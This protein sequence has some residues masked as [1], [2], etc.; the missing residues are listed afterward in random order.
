VDYGVKRKKSFISVP[1]KSQLC[2]CTRDIRPSSEKTHTKGAQM[3]TPQNENNAERKG[4]FDLQQTY[5]SVN[6]DMQQHMSSWRS[7]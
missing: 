7:V 5:F 4:S 1:T 6:N 2:K 3:W